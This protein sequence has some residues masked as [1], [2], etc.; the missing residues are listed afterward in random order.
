MTDTNERVI[1]KQLI[2]SLRM[3]DGEDDEFVYIVEKLEPKHFK[4]Y[5]KFFAL[6]KEAYKEAWNY[7]KF[8][9]T[10]LDRN[11][12]PQLI[13]DEIESE[14]SVVDYISREYLDECI[15]ELIKREKIA[16]IRQSNSIEEIAELATIDEMNTDTLILGSHNMAQL[17]KEYSEQ[18]HESYPLPF[19]AL[20]DVIGELKRDSFVVIAGSTGTGKSTMLEHL[21]W[22]FNEIGLKC[23]LFSLEMDRISILGKHVLR[24]KGKKLTRENF[25]EETEEIEKL[26]EDTGSLIATKSFTINEIEA[27]TRKHKPDVILVDYL[28]KVRLP[29]K[30]EYERINEITDRLQRIKM[31]QKCLVIAG[32]QFN[33]ETDNAMSQPKITQLRGSGQIENDAEIIISLWQTKQDNFYET[34]RE[35]GVDVL[36]NRYGNIFIGTEDSRNLLIL[37]KHRVSLEDAKGD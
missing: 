18:S 17:R 6:C 11:I 15:L 22:H 9:A 35:I 37:N 23:I 30:T 14:L 7:T 32:S 19:I 25:D 29:S 1:V 34:H 26:L 5:P 28:Q 24:T 8:W 27:L 20:S 10:A 3:N 4:I 36:K 12:N 21:F 33:R 2:S 13:I 16:R 31:G